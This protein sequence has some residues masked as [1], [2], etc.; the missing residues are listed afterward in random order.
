MIRLAEGR[1]IYII[2]G[3]TD[4]RAGIDGLASI[5]KVKYSL[6]PYA[7]AMYLF[8]GRRADRFKAIYWDAN[9]GFVLL[10]VRLSGRRFKWPR[11]PQEA[12]QI[13]I[14]QYER[15]LQG[16]AVWE[17]SSDKSGAEKKPHR[18]SRAKKNM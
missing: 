9:R 7:N 3:R 4:L 2:C 12:K 18:T 15:L 8:C 6:D 17:K 13:D 16:L 5:V 11:T 10:Y 1:D 14:E